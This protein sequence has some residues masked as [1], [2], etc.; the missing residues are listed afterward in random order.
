MQKEEDKLTKKR[1]KHQKALAKNESREKRI[2]EV[3]LDV[4]DAREVA[5]GAEAT[6]RAAELRAAALLEDA[7]RPPPPPIDVL[8]GKMNNGNS[9]V[10][11]AALFL[12]L[13]HI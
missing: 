3:D 7:M 12:S 9:P 4:I 2:A 10:H 5:T 8:E 13:I 11:V 6:A 1:I